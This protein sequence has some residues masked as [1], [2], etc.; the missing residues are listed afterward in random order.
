LKD[1]PK[2]PD[3]DQRKEEEEWL[4][5]A[6]IKVHNPWIT[7]ADRQYWRKKLTEYYQSKTND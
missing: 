2:T 1:S 5:H 7:D 6:C 4:Q 3:K